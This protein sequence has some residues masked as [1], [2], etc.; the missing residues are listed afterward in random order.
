MPGPWEGK[1]RTR[2]MRCSNYSRNTTQ[3]SSCLR[4]EE[5]GRAAI[6]CHC[7]V[8]SLWRKVAT[9]DTQEKASSPTEHGLNWRSSPLNLD[10][11]RRNALRD[12]G[13]VEDLFH[14]IEIPET[15][16]EQDHDTW[17]EGL[18]DS[19]RALPTLFQCCRSWERS[20]R[21]DDCFSR[22]ARRRILV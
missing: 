16:E 22:D 7:A 1:T 8:D 17:N 15:S 21:R 11:S 18:S 2:R 3:D 4:D 14:A 13:E 5:L 19:E 10:P 6:N 20:R 12:C 9:C